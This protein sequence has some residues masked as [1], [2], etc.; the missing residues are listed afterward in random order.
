LCS[1]KKDKFKGDLKIKEKR[2]RRARREILV[3]NG[4]P[5]EDFN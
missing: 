5:Y 2:E 1:H 4:V 3:Y